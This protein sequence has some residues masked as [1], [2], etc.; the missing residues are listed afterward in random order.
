MA[1]IRVRKCWKRNMVN[2]IVYR[3]STFLKESFYSMLCY[4]MK[5]MACYEIS[6]LCN[7]ISM[8]CYG[9]SILCYVMV[10]VVKYKHIATVYHMQI[11]MV[12]KC[13]FCFLMSITQHCVQHFY[14]W[15]HALYKWHLLGM[16]YPCIMS[17]LNV[18]CK[19]CKSL[20]SFYYNVLNFE[21]MFIC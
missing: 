13:I 17:I 19:W 8:L 2:A 6:M 20:S 12:F 3:V 7:A 15:K 1:K 9:I 21:R 11:E 5:F 14:M 4:C 10:Y 16:Y 18:F